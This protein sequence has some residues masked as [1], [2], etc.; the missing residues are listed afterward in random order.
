MMDDATLKAVA[1]A[2]VRLARQQGSVTVRDIPPK[3]SLPDWR[4]PSGATSPPS[5]SLS[6]VTV[7]GRYFSP[8][9]VS[10]RRAEAD[11]QNSSA[12]PKPCAG[13]YVASTAPPPGY[14][15]AAASAR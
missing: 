14:A 8:E 4:S 3:P 10:R 11:A 1:D 7:R 6:C 5:P 9:P 12:L 2:V 15:N 13:L